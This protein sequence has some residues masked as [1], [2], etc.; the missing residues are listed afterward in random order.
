MLYCLPFLLYT[1]L[2]NHRHSFL[3]GLRAGLLQATWVHYFS[4]HKYSP[5]RFLHNDEALS[6]WKMKFSPQTQTPSSWRLT[7]HIWTYVPPLNRPSMIRR[8]L[9]LADMRHPYHKTFTPLLKFEKIVP[10]CTL[11]SP[12]IRIPIGTIKIPYIE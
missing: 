11:V 7:V 6:C 8:S 3:I 2:V 9:P 10:R 1:S 12:K 4:P 5:W